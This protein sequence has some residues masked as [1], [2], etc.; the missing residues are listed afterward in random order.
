MANDDDGGNFIAGVLFGGSVGV[1][2]GVLLAPKAGAETRAELAGQSEVWRERAEEIAA[3]VRERVGPAVEG[4]R[5]RVAPAM[6]S[7]RERV[8]P[9]ADAINARMG[10]EAAVPVVDGGPAADGGSADEA[11]AGEAKS[12]SPEKPA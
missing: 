8:A 11:D 12:S 7:M 10:R 1:I 4:V 2:V 6:E 9:V 5:E 3:R